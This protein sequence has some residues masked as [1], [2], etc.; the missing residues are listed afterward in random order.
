[1]CLPKFQVV[2]SENMKKWQSAI[3]SV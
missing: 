2:S 1:L 3:L